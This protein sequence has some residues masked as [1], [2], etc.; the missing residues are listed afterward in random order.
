MPFNEV[1]AMSDLLGGAAP[2]VGRDIGEL[3]AHVGVLGARPEAIS[4]KG[5]PIPVQ[6]T[7]GV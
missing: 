7:Q 4:L 3:G 1:F 6:A 2:Q 5:W